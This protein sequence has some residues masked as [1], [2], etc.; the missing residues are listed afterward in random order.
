MCFD[1]HANETSIF[2]SVHMG[3]KKKLAIDT[4]SFENKSNFESQ[5]KNEIS[6]ENNN[7]DNNTT[8]T[9]QQQQQQQLYQR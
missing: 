7:S 6:N 9:Q 4:N 3:I 5:N 8:S 2:V 1:K